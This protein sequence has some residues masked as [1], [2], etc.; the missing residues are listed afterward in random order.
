MTSVAQRGQ[1][2][3]IDPESILGAFGFP[4]GGSVS[5]VAYGGAFVERPGGPELETV[6]PT[7]GAVLARVGTA[8]EADYE[9]ASQSARA[10]FERWRT[11]PGPQ[12]GATV[13]ALG[14]AFRARKEDLAR[15]ISLE[16]GKI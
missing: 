6:D 14:D 1:E 15:L 16:N 9:A 11:V 4:A 5:G 8:G 3:A 7:T 12:R 13:R 10:A 2:R